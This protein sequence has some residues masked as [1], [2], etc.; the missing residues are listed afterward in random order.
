MKGNNLM[1][2]V[3]IELRGIT[4][5]FG[6]VVANKGVNLTVCNGEILS[7]LGENGSGKTTLMNMISGIYHPDEGQIIIG[8]EEVSIN[9]PH[10]AFNYKIGMIHQHFKLVDLFTAAENIILGLDEKGKFDIKAVSQKVADI[11]SKYGFDIDP[12][13]KIYEM[14]V[15]EKQTV[16]I[17]KVLYRG[18]DILILDEPTAVLTPQETRKLFD[19]LRRMRDDGKAII[20]IT[21]KLHEVLDLSDKVAVLRHGEYVGTVNT[22]EADENILTEMMV[23]KKVELN[24][25]RPEPVDPQDRLVVEHIDCMSREGVKLLDDV[26]FTVRSGEI[27]GIAGIAGSGQRELLEAIAGLQKLDGGSIIYNNPK[28]GKSENLRDKTPLEIRELGVRLSFVPEDRLGM[29]L[30][31]N[32]SVIDNMMLRS[33]RRGKSMF[34]ERHGPEELAHKIIKDLEVATPDA[35]TPVRRLSGGNVQKILLGREI[36]SSPTL[37]MA[38]YPV[39]GL[40]INSSYLIYD[41]LNDQKRKGVA[42]IFVGEDL[43]VLLDLCD[44]IMV[45]GSGRITGI[46]DGRTATKNEVGYLMTKTDREEESRDAE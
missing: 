21:H 22:S 44:R 2:N 38:A 37:L 45:I 20:I 35:E 16:E 1:S 12:S 34:V 39:R 33:Y 26:S 42:V 6:S 8:G 11:S 7:L 28:T 41:L 23:G 17:I 9:S 3:A 36:S 40:D 18:A 31:G 24:I 19:I 32:M 10:D 30:V 25:E 27:F 14:S 15:S 13:K 4:K 29:G 5:R 46:L 43:D